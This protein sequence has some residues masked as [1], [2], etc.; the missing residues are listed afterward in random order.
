MRS[1]AS[2][3]RLKM[4]SSTCSSS[5][6]GMSSYTTSWPALTMPMSSPALMAWKRKAE[7]MASR[8]TSLPRNENDRLLMPPLT[9]T[10][11][12]DAL[13]WRVASMKWR[14]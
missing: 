7:W 9:R 6:G 8:T 3:R 4:M 2:G 11:G 12:H 5:A 1:V 13:I 14:A 10:P